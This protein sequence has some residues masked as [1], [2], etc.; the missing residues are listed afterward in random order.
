MIQDELLT[1]VY[2]LL[3]SNQPIEGY[4]LLWPCMKLASIRLVNA[5]R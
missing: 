5:G 4:F 2:I 1:Q 3:Q